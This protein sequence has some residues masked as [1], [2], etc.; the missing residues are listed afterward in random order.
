MNNSHFPLRPAVFLDRDGTINEDFGYLSKPEQLTLLPGA[1]AALRKL[2]QGGF[3]PVV[4]T[5]QS[6]VARGMLSWEDLQKINERLSQMLAQEG[7]ELALDHFYSCPHHPD[8][9]PTDAE[10]HCHCRKPD[11]GLFEKAAADLNL[12]LAASVAIGDRLRDVEGPSRLGCQA[13]L[14]ATGAE[15]PEVIPANVHL[16]RDLAEAAQ[17]I[18]P[19]S[20]DR[21]REKP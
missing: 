7:V 3:V 17:L 6:G 2:Q 15:L 20:E 18:I 9:S 21:D 8:F 12:N 14:V 4:V 10:R 11:T 19:D 1:A 16:C 5:N 13:Y